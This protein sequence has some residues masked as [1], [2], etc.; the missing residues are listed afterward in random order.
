MKKS[1]LNSEISNKLNERATSKDKRAQRKQR[2]YIKVSISL[3]QSVVSLNEIQ[4]L[5]KI[6]S[7]KGN[8]TE[9]ANCVSITQWLHDENIMH[10]PHLG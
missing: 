2:A 9:D 1:Y 6:R 4:T 10:G 5:A 7:F 3:V 8:F